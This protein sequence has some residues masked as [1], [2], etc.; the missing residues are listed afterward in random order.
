MSAVLDMA[1]DLP[2]Y[3]V[4]RVQWSGL[5]MAAANGHIEVVKLLLEGKSVSLAVVNRS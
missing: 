1:M 3:N 2:V 5:H 4:F